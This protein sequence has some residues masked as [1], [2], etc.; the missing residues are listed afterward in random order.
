MVNKVLC[1]VVADG[2]LTWFHNGS[3]TLASKSKLTK[4]RR[5]L[6]VNL[7]FEASADET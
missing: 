1:E 6:F 3:S 7:D 5:R 2:S 4:S